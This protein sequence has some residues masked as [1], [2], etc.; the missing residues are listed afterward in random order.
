M[1]R[2]AD[3]TVCLVIAA[4]LDTCHEAERARLEAHGLRAYL[5]DAVIA[6]R[7]TGFRGC[8]FLGATAEFTDADHPVRERVTAHREWLAAQLEHRLRELG[9]PAS[10]DAA[11]DLMLALD[12]AHAGAPAGDAIAAAAAL[13][14]A[15]E[16]VL[17][18]ASR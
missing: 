10:G 14:H 13:E 1:T 2:P 9:H 17:A 6:V 15:A 12:G 18:E 11:D 7:E 16:R 8:P 4:Y 3:R 5:A